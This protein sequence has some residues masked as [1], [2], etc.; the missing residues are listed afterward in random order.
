MSEMTPYRDLFYMGA[1][2][3]LLETKSVVRFALL[4]GTTWFVNAVVFVGVL[5]AV[6]LAIEVANRRPTLNPRILYL[7]L[8]GSLAAAWAIPEHLILELSFFPRILAAIVITFTPIFLANLVFAQRFKDVAASTIAFGANLIGAM[9]GGVMEYSALLVGYRALLIIVA[10]L[11]GLAF[12]YGHLWRPR[13]S[14]E[15]EEALSESPGPA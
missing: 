13:E 2:F 8:I 11:Y 9:V 7:L 3:L 15:G 6:L 1:A 4:F 10:V 14:R 5:L 12:Y